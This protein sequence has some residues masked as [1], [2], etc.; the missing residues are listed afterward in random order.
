MHRQAFRP[1]AHD[2]EGGAQMADGPQQATTH[3]GFLAELKRRRVI[4]VLLLYAVVGWIVIEVASIVLP[5]LH[6][7]SWAITLVIVLVALGFPIALTLAWAVDLG[8]H[9]LQR[10]APLVAAP[11]S[12]PVTATADP[13]PQSPAAAPREPQREPETRHTIAVLPFVNMS[14]D[15]ENEY[16]SDG[17][18]EEIL[19]LLTKLPQLK[20]SSR[21]SSFVFKGK[22]A[23][24]PMVA[25]ELGVSSVLEGSVRRAGEHVRITAQL[26]ET[27]TD[28]HLWSETYDRE[29][30][31]VF[32]I[33]DD[34][35]RSIV[36]ALQI[37]LSPKERRALQNVATANASAYD[38]YLRGRRYFYAM[39][40]RDFLNA[41]SMF[42]RAIELDPKY[43]MAYAGLADTYSML[44]RYADASQK[45]MLAARQASERAIELDPDSA[46]AQASLGIALFTDGQ[47]TASE[48][49]F[50]TALLINPNQFESYLFYGRACLAKGDYE[51]AARLFIR[52]S[53]VN[54][55][56][57][58]SAGFLSMAYRS[59]GRDGLARQADERS[60]ELVKRQVLMNPDDARALSFG[61]YSLAVAGEPE[62]A[63]EWAEKVLQTRDDE[64]HYLYNSACVYAALDKPSRA[65]DLL[66]RAVDLGW[67]DRAWIENDS[68]LT[69]LRT[70]PRFAALLER[71][72]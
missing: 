13:V 49:H 21:T 43:A 41:I 38:F 44:Y 66:E 23:G 67:G 69:A 33:Q 39:S 27:D 37:A 16:F 57:Y 26:I 51:K 19:N 58:Q 30:K 36:D 12:E 35:A 6:L 31:D 68:D 18:S 50:E 15:A 29:M 17:I 72:G 1:A 65:L 45:N 63:A 64:P 22:E 55:S 4:R 61:A 10:T 5:A 2:V 8:P 47:Y 20:V 42:E 28:S 32:A 48:K 9:G 70:D 54:P 62:R 59:C 53:E 60:L 7:P 25:R 34:I 71:M 56:D 40:R 14:G 46:E 3:H 52:A 11:P 24:I